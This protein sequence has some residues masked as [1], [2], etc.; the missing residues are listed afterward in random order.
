MITSRKDVIVI[1]IMKLQS[2][3]NCNQIHLYVIGNRSGHLSKLLSDRLK[4]F[5]FLALAAKVFVFL[6]LAAIWLSR[7]EPF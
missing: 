7:E 1:V 4:V 6:A 2:N 3:C 5:V